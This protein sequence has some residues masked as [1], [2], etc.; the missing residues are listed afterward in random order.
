LQQRQVERGVAV[1]YLGGQLAA[2]W[3]QHAHG[4]VVGINAMIFGGD[5]GVA[6]PSHV[7]SAWLAGPP[8]RRTYLGVAIQPVRLQGPARRGPWAG[9]GAALRVVEVKPGGPAALAGIQP[10]DVLLELDG[11]PL[12]HPDVLLDAIDEHTGE[13]PVQLRVLRRGALLAVGVTPG[14]AEAA[15]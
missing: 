2:I 14:V 15:V 5:M 4:H 12:Y 10:D 3:Q 13:G 11:Q 7:A 8:S 1:H 6:I 9:Q